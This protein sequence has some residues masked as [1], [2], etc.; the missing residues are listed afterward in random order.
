[1]A[2]ENDTGLPDYVADHFNYL[3]RSS[4]AARMGQ[5]SFFGTALLLPIMFVTGFPEWAKGSWADMGA[6]VATGVV[7]L[8][9]FVW[10]VQWMHRRMARFHQERPSSYS[11]WFG[12]RRSGPLGGF[13]PVGHLRLA[14]MQLRYLLLSRE[15]SP[16]ETFALTMYFVRNSIPRSS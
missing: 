5:I 7:F 11:R 2:M 10:Y 14:R 12:L 9:S 16:A 4:K 1:M 15:P 8:A 6:M 13:D 3:V